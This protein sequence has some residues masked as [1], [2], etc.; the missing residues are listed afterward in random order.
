VS[1]AAGDSA[2]ANPSW[3]KAI[4]HLVL[5]A[6]W[7]A[8]TPFAIRQLIRQ[9]LTQET[10]KLGALVPGFGSYVN[11]YVYLL[12][13]SSLFILTNSFPEEILFV[14]FISVHELRN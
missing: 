9:G 13:P 11:E 12:N 10:Q 1:Q 4:H 5:V 2:A 14:T 6:G 8:T 3:R 7:D